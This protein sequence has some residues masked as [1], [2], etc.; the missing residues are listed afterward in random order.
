MDILL[1]AGLERFRAFSIF[2]PEGNS[3]YYNQENIVPNHGRLSAT[4]TAMVL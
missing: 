1:L 4:S 2:V 3:G